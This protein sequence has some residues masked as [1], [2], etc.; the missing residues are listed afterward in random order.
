MKNGVI[1][2]IN[3]A[4]QGGG[5]HGALL[6]GILDALLEDDKI[7]FDS[8]SATSA[9]AIN[10]T[11]LAHG[12]ANGGKKGAREALRTFWETVSNIS[13]SYQWM[14][15]TPFESLLGTKTENS[16]SY[17]IFDQLN[18]LFSPYQL[19]PLNINPLRDLIKKTVD[20]K[21]INDSS[22]LQLFIS[23]T[24]VKT[25]K[26]RV[27]TNNEINL[28]SVMA[29]AC[30][31]FLFQAVKIKDDYYWDGGYMGNPA[32]FPLFYHSKCRDILILHINPIYRENVPNTTT[33]ILNRVNE[34]SFNS[35]LMRE[36]RAV[37]FINKLLD[38]NWIKD[39][40]KDQIH[41]YY[42]HAIRADV[43]MQSFS[44]ASKMNTDWDFINQLYTEGR[45]QGIAW[46]E[47]HQKDI[48]K[49]TSIDMSE[50][51]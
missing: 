16:V 13:N 51:L 1:K 24:N 21:K 48:G 23:A 22:E 25:G 30:L 28:D 33:E 50:Y 34:I 27:F 32:I 46:L 6:W 36:M 12:L 2:R 20:F 5:A 35:S 8:I 3:L 45:N 37:S 14:K 44:M 11:I 4:M 38:E 17:M 40:Y 18:K 10:A 9:G 19:N 47:T 26:I 39:E 42:M 7:E 49:K 43:T 31:P 15:M 41:R 29:S